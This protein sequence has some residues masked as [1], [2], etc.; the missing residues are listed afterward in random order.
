MGERKTLLVKGIG[1]TEQA[2]TPTEYAKMMSGISR[3]ARRQVSMRGTVQGVASDVSG[4]ATEETMTHA[5]VMARM[6]RGQNPVLSPT[7]PRRET[8]RRQRQG[9]IEHATAA[10]ETLVGAYRLAPVLGQKMQNLVV[11]TDEA[12]EFREKWLEAN[13]G[14]ALGTDLAMMAALGVGGGLMLGA[15]RTAAA[16][17]GLRGFGNLMALGAGQDTYMYAQY[18]ADHNL[19]FRAEDYARELMIGS[20]INLPLSAATAARG[21]AL[22]LAGKGLEGSGNLLGSVADVYITK[23]VFSPQGTLQAAQ[24]AQKGAGFR[25]LSKLGRKMQGKKHRP[26]TAWT[27]VEDAEKFHKYQA[28]QLER[29][30]PER[31]K[32]LDEAAQRELLDEVR[33]W[34]DSNVKIDLDEVNRMVDRIRAVEKQAVK[35]DV[36]IDKANQQVGNWTKGIGG[37]ASKK[38]TAAF[39][40]EVEGLFG[41]METLGYKD[42]AGT[43]QD[44]LAPG[45]KKGTLANNPMKS[46][47]KLVQM[48]LNAQLTR[49]TVPG[50]AAV[51]EYIRGMLGRTDIWGTGKVVKIAPKLNDAIDDFGKAQQKFKDLNVKKH[52]ND[53]SAATGRLKSKGMNDALNEMEDAIGA[54]REAKQLSESQTRSFIKSIKQTRDT[55]KESGMAYSTAGKLNDLR[56]KAAGTLT[57]RLAQVKQGAQDFRA[58]QASSVAEEASKLMGFAGNAKKALQ[59]GLAAVGTMPT[60]GVMV[61]RHMNRDEKSAM[62]GLLAKELAKMTGAPEYL[63]EQLAG[64]LGA[65]EDADPQMTIMGATQAT[66]TLH[67]LSR[68]LPTPNYTLPGGMEP[69]IMEQEAFLQKFAA[70]M[71]PVSV[72]YAALEGRATPAML[73]ALRVTQQAAY[74]ELSN[75][76]AEAIEH[77]NPLKASRK[78]INGVQGFL[79][80]MDPLYSGQALM[81]LQSN[82]AQNQQQDQAVNGLGGAFRQDQSGNENAFTS[83]Q[84]L[85]SY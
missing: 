25:M 49:A 18:L 76:L 78:T 56:G 75:M 80:G 22:R 41:L 16:T 79:G 73:D 77:T 42:I 83:T 31:F 11:G 62:Y 63:E 82:Y 29:L 7:D 57:E 45:A 17:M 6:D 55:L 27:P 3:Q 85:Q 66:Y 60:T 24:A 21:A 1:G 20:L 59:F 69:S 8:I 50:A 68:S 13:P 48:R 37:K 46:Y 30:K 44:V 10:D 4:R 33:G 71:D 52:L 54:L 32:K 26:T 72:A 47:G 81:L 23:A 43:L 14:Q 35:M 28:K 39:V 36:G 5:E 58:S 2:M 64:V 34:A 65:T 15:G 51:D 19:P 74:A 61:L 84:R 40:T 38:Q 9:E 53:E 67:Y 70:I 12:T